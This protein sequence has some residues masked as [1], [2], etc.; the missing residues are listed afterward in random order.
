M[1][2]RWMPFL[3]LTLVFTSGAAYSQPATPTGMP[4]QGSALN[5]LVQVVERTV[6]S[7]PQVISSIQSFEAAA[8]GQRVTAG[9]MRPEINLQSQVGHDWRANSPDDPSMT[10]WN[11]YGYSLRLR[12]LL[13]DGNATANSVKQ[14]GFE[15]LSS[16]FDVLTI[17]DSVAM[18]AISAYIDVQ[19]FRQTI[20]LAQ[21]NYEIHERTLRLLRERLESGVGR[22]VDTEQAAGRLALAQTNLMTENTNLNDVTQRFRRI[23]GEFPSEQMAPVPPVALPAGSQAQGFREFLTSNPDVL[24]KQA[25]VQASQAGKEAARGAFSPTLE[26]QAS[27]GNDR[28]Q[29]NSRDTGT[30]NSQ[31]QLVMSYNLYRG[32]SD[33][34][35]LQQASALSHAAQSARDYTCR[36]L[37]Q[38]LA[39]TWNNIKRLEAQLPFLKEHERAMEKVSKGAEQQ[40]QIGQRSLLDLLDTANELFDSRRARLNGE[41]D[42]LQQQY[43]WLQLAHRLLPELGLA[44]PVGS[45]PDESRALDLPESVVQACTTPIPNTRNLTPVGVVYGKGAEPPR[46]TPLATTDERQGNVT[47]PEPINNRRGPP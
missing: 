30:F 42:L 28:D 41:F 7:N 11:R 12:Q 4:S 17:V 6:S 20:K 3:L 15:K 16:Y 5:S 35:R 45:A 26:L 38:E 21:E 18:E 31:V 13:Y 34:A 19:R 46:L 25:L 44:K 24:S 40:F 23:V 22:G 47:K 8:Q 37:Q 32:G 43:Q 29:P 27:T 10:S 9:A 14:L 39:I 36:N 2:C 1:L 33:T